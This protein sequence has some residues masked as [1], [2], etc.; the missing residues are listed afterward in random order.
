VPKAKNKKPKPLH[1]AK[2]DRLYLAP[3]SQ[4]ELR[5]LGRSLFKLAAFMSTELFVT[6]FYFLVPKARIT[7]LVICVTLLYRK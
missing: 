6:N 7:S 1:P 5:T 2:R 4:G 3:G